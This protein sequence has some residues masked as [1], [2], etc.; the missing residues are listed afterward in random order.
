MYD[1]GPRLKAIREL[2]GMTQKELAERLNKSISAVSSYECNTQMPPG[3]VLESLGYILNVSVDYLLGID[4]SC[5]YSTKSLTPE[6]R[7]L[8]ELL[9][10]EFTKPTG[11][12]KD[13][14]PEQV[15]I[16]QKLFACFASGKKNKEK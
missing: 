10:G 11:G 16:V 13:L 14:S 2:R 12:S 15:V 5:S 1:L 7:E 6:Q 8:V 9:F 3:D 4:Q